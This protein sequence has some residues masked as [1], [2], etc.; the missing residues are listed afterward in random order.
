MFCFIAYFTNTNTSNTPHH[1]NLVVLPSSSHSHATFLY[2]PH[3]VLT[4][5][6]FK[7]KMKVH[8]QDI[9]FISMPYQHS[10]DNSKKYITYTEGWYF[11]Y[12]SV[13]RRICVHVYYHY[14]SHATTLND[15][16][17]HYLGPRPLHSGSQYSQ[18][19]IVAIVSLSIN[20]S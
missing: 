12:I 5:P 16:A 7:F 14:I 20:T 10:L 11:H 1:L 18:G 6:R 15:Y 9:A 17:S 3:G 13:D 19:N 2:I 8:T 4:Q